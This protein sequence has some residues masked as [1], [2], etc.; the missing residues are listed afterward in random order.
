[1]M[2][3]SEHRNRGHV[4]KH[5]YTYFNTI[6]SAS[7]NSYRQIVEEPDEG[8]HYFDSC[9]EDFDDIYEFPVDVDNEPAS[10][11]NNEE[12]DSSNATPRLFKSLPDFTPNQRYHPNQ[13][14]KWKD[15]CHFQS[16]MVLKEMSKTGNDF[17]IG[18]VVRGANHQHNYILDRLYTVNDQVFASAFLMEFFPNGNSAAI[19]SEKVDIPLCNIMFYMSIIQLLNLCEQQL[20][21]KLTSNDVHGNRNGQ[22]IDDLL[23][24]EKGLV[25]LSDKKTC[26]F[27]YWQFDPNQPLAFVHPDKLVRSNLVHLPNRGRV[28]NQGAIQGPGVSNNWSDLGFKMTGAEELLKLEAVDL[29]KDLPVENLHTLLLGMTKYCFKIAHDHFLN[30]GQLEKLTELSRNYNS[31]ALHRNL[32]SSLSAY[33]SYLDPNMFAE[34]NDSFVSMYQ[35]FNNSSL[36]TSLVY[37]E[38]I[39]NFN[40]YKHILNNTVSETIR[41][42]DNLHH[43]TVSRRRTEVER[44]AGGPHTETERCEQ[45][46]K[47]MR[48][49]LCY[50]NRRNGG[51]DVDIRFAEEYMLRHI[52]QGGLFVKDTSS[53]FW[54]SCVVGL[55]G[56]SRNTNSSKT[57]G[58]TLGKIVSQANDKRLLVEAYDFVANAAIPEDPQTCICERC[59]VDAAEN[60]VV[61]RSSVD[62]FAIDDHDQSAIILV[63][64][65]SQRPL[66]HIPDYES[67]MF[68]SINKSKFGSYWLLLNTDWDL[69]K[70][71]GP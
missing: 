67:W 18:D 46:H 61:Q 63:L 37:M 7:E 30:D 33:R 21:S 2:N 51:R 13:G 28:T 50:T 4:C 23:K 43:T 70:L 55:A 14:W 71:A 36:F 59:L 25:M 8:D 12:M 26:S 64:D 62:D 39:D 40:Y 66:I 56:V 48:E 57:S 41:S 15:S 53:P 17:W 45:Q 10:E 58:L 6:V 60:V 29:S 11:F 24:L 16:P 42:M 54:E 32:T 27:C 19:S 65:M 38:K 3:K 49:L 47:F 68:L 35:C 20:C 5:K 69:K 22:A 52:S 1:M 9:D 44:F 31:K 34:N